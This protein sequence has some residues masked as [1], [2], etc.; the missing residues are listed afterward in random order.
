MTNDAQP[1]LGPAVK[2]PPPALFVAGLGAG[3]LIDRVI[4]AGWVPSGHRLWELL[5]VALGVVGLAVVYT[6]IIS[7]RRH[8]TAVYPN[9]PASTLVASG[10]YAHT[11]NPM[12]VGMTTF[13]VGGVLLLHSVGALL[14]LPVVLRLLFVHVV[15]REEAHL[16]AAFP[17]EY[18][19]Y[20]ATVRRW[21]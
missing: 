13:Y 19:R 4:P 20:C 11:R 9:R 5:G 18:A 3:V 14:L 12:Y 2:F 8:R 21:L 16:R 15:Q 10:V 17:E 7:F 6:G 1:D